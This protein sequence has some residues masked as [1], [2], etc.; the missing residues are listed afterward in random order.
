[1]DAN[2]LLE[3]YAAG[4]RDFSGVELSSISHRV[5]LSGANLKEA[6]LSRADLFGVNLSHTN[7]IGADLRNAYLDFADLRGTEIDSTTKI[8]EKWRIVWEIVNQGARKRNLQGVNLESADLK[9]VDLTDADL[10]CAYLQ[11]VQLSRANLRGAN[12][13]NADLTCAILNEADLNG[14]NL[15]KAYLSDAWLN[16][17]SLSGAKLENAYMVGTELRN[18][19]LSCASLLA[20]NLIKAD[21]SNAYLAGATLSQANLAHANLSGCDLTDA[22]LSDANLVGTDF[23]NAK[24]VGTKFSGTIVK[25]LG[26][27]HIKLAPTKRT[28]HW[29]RL[30]FRSKYEVKI[31]EA[32]DRA[33]LLY[34]ANSKARL[35][36]PEGRQNV[37]PDFLVC[38][39]TPKGFRWGIIEVD[40]PSHTSKRRVKEQERER[41]FE[42]S[43]V[44]VYRFDSKRCDEQPDNVVR[45]LLELLS[46]H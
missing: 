30:G 15:R 8:D 32:L 5:D 3:L 36:T 18:A 28:I 20:A 44:R 22:D 4:K 11:D 24:L 37:E 45:E 33:G 6:N 40:D 26:L 9:D 43:G 13:Y 7:L 38:C 25:E 14:A 1:M 31:A 34:F 27:N 21:L 17:A 29:N 39:D 23:T 19:H 2:E 46:K 16:D 42:H 35:N 10:S 41:Y 12:F